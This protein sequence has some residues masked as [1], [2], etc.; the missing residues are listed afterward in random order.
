MIYWSLG[1]VNIQMNCE[2][3]CEMCFGVEIKWV[4]VLINMEG[5]GGDEVGVFGGGETLLVIVESVKQFGATS[6]GP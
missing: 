6:R 1:I 2:K 4:W 3:M 5:D